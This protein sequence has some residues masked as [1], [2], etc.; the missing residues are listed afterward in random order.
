MKFYVSLLVLVALATTASAQSARSIARARMAFYP[1]PTI[2]MPS[3]PAPLD[4]AALEAPAVLPAPVVTKPYTPNFPMVEVAQPTRRFC[5][6]QDGG[7][8]ICGEDCQCVQRIQAGQG[9]P[10]RFDQPPIQYYQPGPVFRMPLLNMRGSAQFYG[11]Q[12]YAGPA[13]SAGRC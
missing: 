9:I 8:C 10:S 4:H 7:R 2:V 13:V 3:A 11:P 1:G 5:E 6:C 12:S